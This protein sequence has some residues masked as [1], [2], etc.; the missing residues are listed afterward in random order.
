MFSE[1]QELKQLLLNFTKSTV[2][3]ECTKC[4]TIQIIHNEDQHDA[5][6]MLLELGW[7]AT[8]QHC[9][10]PGCKPHKLKRK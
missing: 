5:V 1:L 2:E 3:V 4:G 6:E 9:Y 8:R 10:C 7:L